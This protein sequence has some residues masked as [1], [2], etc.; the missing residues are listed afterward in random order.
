[1]TNL[2]EIDVR[3]TDN[4]TRTVDDVRASL[5]SLSGES[6]IPLIDLRGSEEA[7]TGIRTVGDAMSSLGRQTATP[8]VRLQ[9][10]AETVAESEAVSEAVRK[11]GS[12]GSG[13]AREVEG[14]GSSMGGLSGGAMPALIGAG[15]ALS[16]VIA[17]VGIGL[18]GLGLAA[19]RTVSPIIAA[20]SA[21]GGLKQNMGSLTPVQQ[22]MA[23]GLL[24]LQGQVGK[25]TSSLQPEVVSLW[26]GAL[27][28]AGGLLGDIQPVAK[29]T[30]DALSGVVGDIA[31]DLKTAQWQ[32]FFQFMAQSAGPDIQLVGKLFTDLMN[33]LPQLLEELQ[34]VAEGL[35]T[36]ADDAA[37][38]F[39]A[40]D[41]LNPSLSTT[42][43]KAAEVQQNSGNMFTRFLA[44][45]KLV[46]SD[47]TGIGKSTDTA[48]A[49]T[50]TLGTSAQATVSPVDQLGQAMFTA[51]ADTKSLD[52]AWNELV[53]NFNSEQQSIVAAEQA[54]DNYGKAVKQS[55]ATSLAAQSAFYTS[56]TSLQQMTDAEVKNHAPAAQLYSDLQAEIN[57]L[58]SK[59]PLNKAEQQDLA[60]LQK[61]A[62]AAAYST[63]GLTSADK[64]AASSI[65]GNLLP[66]VKALH[67]SGTT[68]N[69]DMRD[70]AASIVNTGTQSQATKSARDAL[71]ADLVTAG[72]KASTAKSDVDNFQRSV[73][74]LTGKTVNVNV[75]GSGS[76]TIT[77]AEQNIKNAQTGYLEFHAAGGIVGGSGNGDTVPA[78]LTPGEV[79]VP[80][81]MVQAGAVDHLR[82]KLPGFASGGLVDAYGVLSGVGQDF[83]GTAMSSAGKS[84]ENAA[85]QAMVADSLAKIA[86]AAAAV[87][88][89]ATGGVPANMGIVATM[90][91]N[92]AAARGWTGPQW[93][94]LYAVEN[95]EAGFSMTATNPSSGA[96]GLAQFINGPSE[97]A[98]Y[99]GNST[100]ATGQ[101]TG[102]LNYIAQRYGSPEAAWAH[103]VNFGWYDH[104]GWL[105][106]GLTMA[107]N[108]T[109]QPEQVGGAPGQ[110]SISFELGSS[111]SATFDEFMLTW[112][113]EHA[114]I[115]G[116]GSVQ[117]AFGRS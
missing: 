117:A 32:N 97:Y 53:G 22:G 4:A 72:V 9:G 64:F 38:A 55:G 80:R 45:S 69:T 7:D 33:D 62:D 40:L 16:P 99:G 90:M 46:I 15:V 86:A 23:Q 115:K 92:M 17:T 47:L 87:P 35:L 78:M 107:Y 54:V 81:G 74:G 26:G 10:A 83:M 75:V 95:R 110:V 1:M 112:I 77:F 102:M 60:N 49:S 79:V 56:V 100:T 52:A 36:V 11:V 63:A 103:E 85:A 37:L 41:T 88:T 84:V 67:A 70:L 66:Q 39:K 91:R 24:T 93:D 98:Q 106:P 28:L 59:G 30:G 5:R 101:I 12:S 25:F 57:A 21:T 13:A 73:S 116:G 94:A 42:S 8:N 71:I 68:L 114:R 6:A 34:P 29:A 44:S 104:G 27:K 20:A 31:A 50:R 96:Y 19:E 65:E 89:A 14:L 113:R 82:G 48:S 2:V 108:G 111:G 76:G 18:G 61:A 43:V 105:K 3:A 51:A 58:K 109:G